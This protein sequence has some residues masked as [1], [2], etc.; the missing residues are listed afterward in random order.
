M[1][2]AVTF[3]EILDSWMS[4]KYMTHVEAA[5][6]LGV[7][8]KTIARWL[9]SRSVPR[10]TGII[11]RRLEARIGPMPDHIWEHDREVVCA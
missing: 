9:A 6:T 7:T 11:R 4:R 8:E 10:E 5:R 2:A 1:A 3:A